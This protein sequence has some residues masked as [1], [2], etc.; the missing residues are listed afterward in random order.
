[1]ITMS[2]LSMYYSIFAALMLLLVLQAPTMGR[3]FNEAQREFR[4]IVA[5]RFGRDSYR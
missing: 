1:M 2:T 5:A 3:A 4:T